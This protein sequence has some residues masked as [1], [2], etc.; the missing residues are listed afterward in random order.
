MSKRKVTIY[1]IAKYLKLSPATVSYVL[2][3][4]KKVS[5]ETKNAVL[6]AA[7]EL[8]YS[9]NYSAFSLSTGE[10]KLIAL[11]LPREDIYVSLTQNPFYSELYSAFERKCRKEGYDVLIEP[12]MEQK[13]LS[14][15]IKSRGIDGAVILGLF[16][17]NYHD[18]FSKNEI[19]LTLVDV[20]ASDEEYNIVRFDDYKGAYMSTE[21]LIQN[22]HTNIGFIC[23]NIDCSV[24]DRERYNGYRDAMIQ[25]NLSFNK[26][27]VIFCDATYDGGYQC[28]ES[29]RNKKLTAVVC[30]ADTIAIGVMRSFMDHGLELPDNLSIIGF[31]D[32]YTAKI[33]YPP[34]TTIKQDISYKGEMTASLII[35]AIKSKNSIHKEY[36]VEPSI[37]CRGS[38]KKL[39]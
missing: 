12:L 21:H 24:V 33:V 8:G 20:Y 28:F 10:S 32:I 23:G 35:E 9:R 29:I 11:F 16:P 31:D 36:V 26:D 25:N 3:D 13:E 7:K 15:W 17:D 6:S 5:A 34:L 2:N 39:N 14:S 37:V 18:E 22:G 27:N 1:D 4:K 30:A 38:V 19:P